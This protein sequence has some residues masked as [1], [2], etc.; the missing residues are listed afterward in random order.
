MVGSKKAEYTK[1]VGIFENKFLLSSLRKVQEIIS[2]L[3]QTPL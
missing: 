3:A 1:E 2:I